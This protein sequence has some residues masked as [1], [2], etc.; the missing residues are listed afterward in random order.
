MVPRVLAEAGCLERFYTDVYF[1]RRPWLDLGRLRAFWDA[2]QRGSESR[3][4]PSLPIAVVSDFPHIL[5]A[6][7]ARRGSA[8]RSWTLKGRQF[9]ESVIERGFA[10]AES[11]LAFSSA[12]LEIFEVARAKGIAT[13]LDLYATAPVDSEM[14]TVHEEEK[15]FPGWVPR[16][17]LLDP[18][19]WA[20]TPV[21]KPKS[22]NWPTEFS[23]DRASSPAC[24]TRGRE[25]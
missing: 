5:L 24:S 12:A 20:Q 16:S 23:A 14:A 9:C 17:T 6:G 11:V 19:R 1:G 25:P 15:R 8:T 3:C 18:G 2:D 7:R 4:D 13:I 22:V 10:R 21:V